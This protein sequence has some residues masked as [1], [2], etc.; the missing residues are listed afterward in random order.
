MLRPGKNNIGIKEKWLFALL[1]IL[2][3]LPVW[4]FPYFLTADG[5]CHVYNAGVL[6][7]LLHGK[8]EFFKDFFTV[9]TRP[10]PNWFSHAA[11]VLLMHVFTGMVAEKIL[12]TGCILLF[13]TGF[14]ALLRTLAP[15]RIF[16]SL[17]IFP[18]VWQVAMLM[19][20]YNY[21]YSIGLCFWLSASFIR[22]K[23]DLNFRKGLVLFLGFTLM[24]FM[25][26]FGCMIMYIIC[27]MYILSDKGVVKDKAR[28]IG[29]LLLISLPALLLIAGYV[30]N[31]T[32]HTNNIDRQDLTVLVAHLNN[33][34]SLHGLTRTDIRLSMKL[35]SLLQ[36]MIV[37][38]IISL[39]INRPSK[40]ILVPISLLLVFTSLYFLAYEKTF[41]G[42]YIRPRLEPLIYMSGM[43]LVAFAPAHRLFRAASIVLACVFSAAFTVNKFSAFSDVSLMVQEIRTAGKQIN[44]KST[45]LPLNME[46]LLRN[47]NGEVINI[48]IPLF[49]HVA[50][51]ATERKQI[52]YLDNYEAATGYFPLKWKADKDPFIHLAVGDGIEEQPPQVDIAG[53]EAKYARVDNI[54]MWGADEAAMSHPSYP[55]LMRVIAE[56]YML[57]SASPVYQVKLY[58]RK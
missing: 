42:S 51:Y 44:D 52:I 37:L 35:S 2:V 27:G 8:G 40:K 25:H 14:R 55:A 38:G 19:G 50:E 13:V 28:S 57:V 47:K 10:N 45:V 53:Y 34:N 46:H 24:Y 39:V 32:V 23:D 41:G 48:N 22:N 31:N 3:I 49:S 29:A 33:L 15:E 26:L 17:W 4:I 6:Y 58:R 5:P 1:F 56:N 9:N 12:L 20:F 7:D 43:L 54:L 18:F 30:A 36:A 11:L 16:L 21:M